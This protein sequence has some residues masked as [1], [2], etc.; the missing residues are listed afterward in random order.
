MVYAGTF[1]HRGASIELLA[2][3]AGALADRSIKTVGGVQVH[4][5]FEEWIGD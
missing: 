1:D 3:R 2:C 5:G 4:G